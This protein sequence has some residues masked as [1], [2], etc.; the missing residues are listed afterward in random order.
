LCWTDFKFDFILVA[1][2]QWC[3]PHYD[4]YS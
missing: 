4:K 1:E 3:E 2:K